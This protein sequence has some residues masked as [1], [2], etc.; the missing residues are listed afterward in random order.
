MVSSTGWAHDVRKCCWQH[1]R[2]HASS[3]PYG[4][5]SQLG[6]L[7]ESALAQHQWGMRCLQVRH[8][9]ASHNIMHTVVQRYPRLGCGW[10]ELAVYVPTA[11][12]KVLA[13]CIMPM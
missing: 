11:V 6:F 3:G 7:K 12:V 1:G 4:G 5:S 2:K 8:C 13:E 10:A 9:N